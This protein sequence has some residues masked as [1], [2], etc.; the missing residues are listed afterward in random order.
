[1]RRRGCVV[2]VVSRPGSRTLARMGASLGA[3]AGY[4]GLVVRN[5]DEYV[6][7]A[8]ALARRPAKLARIKA[9]YVARIKALYVNQ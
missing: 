5:V 2:C 6:A 3:A 1:M 8:I 4:T 9:L 7:L